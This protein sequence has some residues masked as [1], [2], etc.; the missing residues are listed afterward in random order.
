MTFTVLDVTEAM[1]TGSHQELD[2]STMSIQNRLEL[3][4]ISF[5]DDDAEEDFSVNH[6]DFDELLDED[7]PI[8][9]SSDDSE[10]ETGEMSHYAHPS[11]SLSGVSPLV[12]FSF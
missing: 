1:D 10:D 2:N 9:I 6:T 7:K 8:V 11:E 3:S 12:S 5:S 4:E